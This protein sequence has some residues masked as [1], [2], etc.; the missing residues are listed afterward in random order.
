M[1]TAVQTVRGPVALTELGQTLMH[2][3]V[4]VMA[5]EAFANYGAVRGRPYWDEEERVIS[6]EV[7]P[8]LLAAGVSSG[9][10]DQMMVANPRA[11]FAL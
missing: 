4:F 10:A 6:R 1:R 8:A 3:H 5:P 11:F 2:V 9:T 7:L